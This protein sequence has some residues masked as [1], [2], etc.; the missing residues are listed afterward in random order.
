M[1]TFAFG[2]WQEKGYVPVLLVGLSVMGM[3]MGC[4]VMPL[5]GSAVQALRPQQVARGSTL[6]N[7]NQ[8]VAGSVWHRADV[9]RPHQPVQP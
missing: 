2:V 3:G 1:G 7:V 8:Q 9:G 6:I 5:S 4:T